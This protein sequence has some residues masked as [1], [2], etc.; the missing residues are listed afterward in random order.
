M[1]H[2][3]PAALTAWRSTSQPGHL[4]RQSGLVDEYQLRRIEIGLAI[5]PG[6]AA[7]QDVGAILL[8]CIW[9]P[10]FTPAD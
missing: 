7:L 8:Q 2:T 1:R 3:G 9:T 5:E 4:G 6:A 10:V